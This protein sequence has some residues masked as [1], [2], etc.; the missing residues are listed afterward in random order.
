MNIHNLFLRTSPILFMWASANELNSFAGAIYFLSE[1][2]LNELTSSP[3]CSELD[4]RS[5]SYLED[6]K[7]KFQDNFP[8]RVHSVQFCLLEFVLGRGH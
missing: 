3:G 1:V 7:F 2:E 8:D 6:G 5:H 4:G